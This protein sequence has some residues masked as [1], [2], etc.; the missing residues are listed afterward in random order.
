MKIL[1]FQNKVIK[2]LKSESLKNAISFSDKR[3]T[4]IELCKIICFYVEQFEDRVNL[5][6]EMLSI[7]SNSGAYVAS[8]N[9]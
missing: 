2:Y 3:F 6:T 4:E 9:F 7:V 1:D 5:L 8:L